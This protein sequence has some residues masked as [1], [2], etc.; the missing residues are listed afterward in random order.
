MFQKIVGTVMLIVIV[1]WIFGDEKKSVERENNK[2]SITS[3]FPEANDSPLQKTTPITTKFEPNIEISLE[4][5]R[6]YRR[7]TYLK[8]LLDVYVEGQGGDSMARRM[9]DMLHDANKEL[10]RKKCH[11][12]E[13]IQKNDLHRFSLPQEPSEG[14][15][16]DWKAKCD[17]SLIRVKEAEAKL[18]KI[19]IGTKATLDELVA[20][21]NNLVAHRCLEPKNRPAVSDI[22]DLNKHL[23][24]NGSNSNESTS[25]R[26]E[27]RSMTSCAIKYSEGL[28]L[29]Y[30]TVSS[31]GSI[32]AV[33]GTARQNAARY[34]WID[35]YQVFTP[36][37]MRSLLQIGLSKC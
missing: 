2:N 1:L 21:N 18:D 30:I 12:Y 17:A 37:Q 24:L 14:E 9:S 7:E 32:F 34:G 29:V 36:E 16:A 11:G 8:Y 6:H 5:V 26:R 10:I 4:C 22:S 23:T 19:N 3:V 20:A 31:D 28:R 15:I 33:N 25:A 35:G 27:L 13:L